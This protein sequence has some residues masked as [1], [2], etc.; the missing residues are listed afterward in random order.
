MWRKNLLA[1]RFS[2]PT[3]PLTSPAL[4][5]T[6]APTSFGPRSE[7]SK[8]PDSNPQGPPGEKGIPAC[9]CFSCST[10]PSRPLYVSQPEL[11]ERWA[12]EKPPVELVLIFSFDCEMWSIA[13]NRIEY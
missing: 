8:V 9:P 1:T 7:R 12:N 5:S 6:P 2:F 11:R 13:R 4:S 3:S 10:M